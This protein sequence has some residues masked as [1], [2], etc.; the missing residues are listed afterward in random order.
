MSTIIAVPWAI[1]I[2]DYV[3]QLQHSRSLGSYKTILGYGGKNIC[4]DFQASI[5]CMLL[6]ASVQILEGNIDHWKNIL[7]LDGI[8]CL[9]YDIATKSTKL[10]KYF[11][12]LDILQKCLDNIVGDANAI[13]KLVDIPQSWTSI[14][15]FK[16]DALLKSDRRC[17]KKLKVLETI[18]SA[19]YF[20]SNDITSLVS[21]TIRKYRSA[22]NIEALNS[23]PKNFY[24]R[25][26]ALNPK[27]NETD[28]KHLVQTVSEEATSLN[29]AEMCGGNSSSNM[30]FSCNKESPRNIGK[31]EVLSPFVEFAIHSGLVDDTSTDAS[32]FSA[33]SS[34]LLG[35]V[36]DIDRSVGYNSSIE[37][38]KF[39]Y[40]MNKRNLIS[41]ISE[42]QELVRSMKESIHNGLLDSLLCEI[43]LL[44]TG[45]RSNKTVF[46]CARECLTENS[47][48][49][50]DLNLPLAKGKSFNGFYESSLEESLQK[51]K[52][53]RIQE[54]SEDDTLDNFTPSPLPLTFSTTNEV[55]NSENPPNSNIPIRTLT[56]GD[57]SYNVVYELG[58]YHVYDVC[59]R[60]TQVLFFDRHFL[61]KSSGVHSIWPGCVI[62][63]DELCHISCPPLS[64]SDK[65][66]FGV[67]LSNSSVAQLLQTAGIV[68]ETTAQ[69]PFINFLEVCC[70]EPFQCRF[71]YLPVIFVGKVVISIGIGARDFDDVKRFMSNYWYD[72][73]HNTASS[74]SGASTSSSASSISSYSSNLAVI[75]PPD[76][77]VDFRPFICID[78][79]SN[80]K[81]WDRFSKLQED[82][83]IGV[84]VHCVETL[85]NG[86]R[87]IVRL[88]N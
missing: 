46:D 66:H 84:L 77:E 78:K 53:V 47:A 14:E 59:F 56:Y 12:H 34:T 6:D 60:D 82:K 83:I 28:S 61:A 16:A 5:E 22:K 51:K 18:I 23:A 1:L 76:N 20:S 50:Y 48:S 19:P 4:F 86:F 72:K 2:N 75:P 21:E 43:S 36:E 11:C 25:K 49:S 74:M 88:V 15:S 55:S 26:R 54:F 81:L 41:S 58:C 32:S 63:F 85:E 7:I 45:K 13:I 37:T 10:G 27:R 65:V 30:D 62:S 73:T 33:S 35:G 42:I 79:H 9:H 38:S 87:V 57:F 8:L 40:E 52:R 80:L 29:V 3:N 64:N 67:V 24:G 39:I 44:S 71:D 68:L 69:D 70:K 17:R 31:R